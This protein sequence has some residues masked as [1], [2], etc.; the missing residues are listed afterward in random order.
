MIYPNLVAPLVYLK[1]SH[2]ALHQ[3]VSL[4]Y[5]LPTETHTHTHTHNRLGDYRRLK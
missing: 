4:S 3:I 2:N 5:M 1:C